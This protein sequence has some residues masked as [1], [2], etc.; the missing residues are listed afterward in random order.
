MLDSKDRRN[1]ENTLRPSSDYPHLPSTVSH[2]QLLSLRGVVTRDIIDAKYEGDGTESDPYIISFV[3]ND[4]GDPKSLPKWK[5]WQIVFSV[6]FISFVSALASSLYIGTINQVEQYFSVSEEVALLGVSLYVLGVATGPLLWAPAGET[7]GRQTTLL[8]TY[9]AFTLFNAGMTASQNIQ[10]MIVLRFFAG[11]TASS[12]FVNATGN[13]ADIFDPSERGLAF[14]FYAVTPF[15]GTFILCDTVHLANGPRSVA[16]SNDWWLLGSSRGVALGYWSDNNTVR[17]RAVFGDSVYTR[18]LRSCPSET[19]RCSY[20]IHNRSKI[21]FA[22][23]S[24]QTAICETCL[25]ESHHPPLGH[26]VPRTD[27]PHAI[28]LDI[29]CLRDLVPHPCRFSICF[30][31]CKRVELGSEWSCLARYRCW[32]R[33]RSSHQRPRQQTV[34]GNG[35]I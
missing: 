14:G 4:P 15:L 10:T 12:P 3:D 23:R 30:R 28:D 34:Y 25:Q 1:S 8:C 2:W 6:S 29:S 20:V 5:K 27:R 17:P 11:A 9:T 13:L 26:P 16:G 21:H 18:D 32:H 22:N 7:Y 35:S 31:G 33:R 19:P 24:V